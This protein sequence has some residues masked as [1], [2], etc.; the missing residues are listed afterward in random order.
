MYPRIIWGQ[1]VG[2]HH[3][4]QE[5]DSPAT[6]RIPRRWYISL[7]VSVLTRLYSHLTTCHL[8]WPCLRDKN[9]EYGLEG[10]CTT[11]GKAIT[12]GRRALMFL[13]G[14][15]E[16]VFCIVKCWSRKHCANK[17]YFQVTFSTFFYDATVEYIN[18]QITPH[19]AL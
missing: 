16:L 13:R 10:T 3:N 5:H 11:V 14:M 6:G 1:A 17:L 18:Y 9:S 7:T 19:L 15:R 12:A 2:N 8:H 4:V